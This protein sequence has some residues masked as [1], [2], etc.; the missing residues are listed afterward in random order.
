MLKKKN[1]QVQARKKGG[2]GR[3][4]T[5]AEQLGRDDTHWGKKVFRPRLE[6]KV[7]RR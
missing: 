4:G 3:I 1:E 6:A 7:M 2:G 5:G